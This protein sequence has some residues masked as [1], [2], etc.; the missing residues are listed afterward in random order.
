MGGKR[1]TRYVAK[2]LEIE[3]HRNGVCGH[4]FYAI[5]FLADG[6]G[7]DEFLAVVPDVEANGADSECYVICTST[8]ATAGVGPG[9]CWRGDVFEPELRKAAK[10]YERDRQQLRLGPV[11]KKGGK[12]GR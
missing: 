5:R 1:R 8:L 11:K 2:V 4:P 3:H 6:S 7:A 12:R 10:K 9:N